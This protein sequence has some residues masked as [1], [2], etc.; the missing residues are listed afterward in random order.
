MERRDGRRTTDV[1]VRLYPVIVTV[2]L[3]VF[4]FGYVG[5]SSSRTPMVKKGKG[6]EDFRR[7][8]FF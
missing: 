8:L 4:R 2:D 7:W 1:G 3:I 5:G 6:K